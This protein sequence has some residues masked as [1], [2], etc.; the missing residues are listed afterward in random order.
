MKSQIQGFLISIAYAWNIWRLN[1]VNDGVLD[2]WVSSFVF[3]ISNFLLFCNGDWIGWPTAEWRTATYCDLLCVCLA[4]GWLKNSCLLGW[5]FDFFWNCVSVKDLLNNLAD[6]RM[7]SST[8]FSAESPYSNQ[9]KHKRVL[10][11][12]KPTAS[13][14]LVPTLQ[15]YTLSTPL[16]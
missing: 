9:G 6:T 15:I 8:S 14:P 12:F 1:I 5:W 7:T 4:D 10:F 13:S 3:F 16:T 2:D 11:G